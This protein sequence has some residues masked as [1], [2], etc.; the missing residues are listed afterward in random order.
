MRSSC[1][2]PRTSRLGAALC[3]A[4]VA[5][6]NGPG[7]PDPA[8]L[9]LVDAIQAHYDSV[10]DLTARFVQTAH[11]AS[12]G[13]DEQADGHVWVKRPGRMRWEYEAPEA[14]VITVDGE[15][16]RLYSPADAQLQIVSL[17]SGAFSPT[18]L[19]FLLG[20]GK[21]GEQFVAERLPD[22]EDGSIQLRLQPRRES[23]FQFLELR[24]APDTHALRSS[25]VV[26]LLGNRTEVRFLELEENRGVSEERF[27]IVVPKGTEVLDLR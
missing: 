2:L 26:D 18:A 4:L 6:G 13:R 9:A 20:T 14:R 17:A 22:G 3:A 10:T 24:V 23:R 16:L 1:R 11:I 15:T 25:T 27:T 8:T 19:D 7:A 21:L 12:L 5:L